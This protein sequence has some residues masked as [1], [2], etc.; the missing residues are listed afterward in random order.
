MDTKPMDELPIKYGMSGLCYSIKRESVWG[1]HAIEHVCFLPAGHICPHICGI[2][3]K[4]SVSG[5]A[6]DC[7]KSWLVSTDEVIG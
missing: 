7:S 3:I 4:N 6:F 2:K 5:I 1:D